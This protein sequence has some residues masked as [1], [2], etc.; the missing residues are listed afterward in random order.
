[1]KNIYNRIIEEFKTDDLT[2]DSIIVSLFVTT[3]NIIVKNNKLIKSLLITDKER[4][5][6]IVADYNKKILFEDVIAIFEKAIPEKDVIINGAIYTPDY[7]RN[8]IVDSCFEQGKSSLNKPINEWTCADISCGCGAFLFTLAKKIKQETNLSYALIFK[9]IYGFDICANSISRAKI[10]LS[11][12]AISEEEDIETFDFKLYEGDSLSNLIKETLSINK[13]NGFDIIVGNPPYVRSKNIDPNI[14]SK[15]KNWHVSSGNVDLYIPFFEIGLV[16][17]VKNGAL[18]YITVNS[19]FKSVNARLLRKYLQDNTYDFSI[20]DFGQ[21]LVFEKKMAYT[22]LAF[23]TKKNQ[24]Y[25]SYKKINSKELNI[26]TRKKI[27]NQIL[28]K[29]L[30]YQKGWQLNN[31]DETGNNISKIERT[32]EPLGEKFPIKNGL[33]TLANNVYIFK[34]IEE[35]MLYYYFIHNGL[36]YKVEKSICKDIIKPNVIKSE[37][38]LISKLE[39]IIFPYANKKLITDTQFSENYPFTY[40][41]LSSK[42]EILNNRDKGKANYEEWFAFGRTQALYNTGKK[43][44]IPYMSDKSYAVYS[45]SEEMLI[46]CGYAIYGDSKE[47]LLLLKKILE[48]AIFNYYIKHTSKP[49]STGYYSYAKNYIKNFGVCDLNAKEKLELSRL[50]NKIDIDI[51]LCHKY[52]ID[53]TTIEL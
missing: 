43:L 39:K 28:Y 22:C 45:D 50:T 24:D 7:I 8:F 40:K 31:D 1:M 49:Y 51:F 15:L 3:N 32:G 13:K 5:N 20:I 9:H 2:I 14:K 17:L 19:F 38:D 42:K 6:N 48:S 4:Y 35:D 12:L 53:I 34:P 30:D 26:N 47:D 36:E 29:Q 23:I 52:N 44:L 27:F 37:I 46:Y 33:A 25:I 21:E 10:L 18:G 16:N 11:L 41:Y